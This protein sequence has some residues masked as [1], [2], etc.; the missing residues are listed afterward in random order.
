MIE[1]S[2]AT[3]DQSSA[4]APLNLA[5][6]MRELRARQGLKQS[7]IARRMG[8]DP[9]IPSLWEQGKRPVPASR[10]PALAAALGVDPRELLQGIPAPDDSAGPSDRSARPPTTEYPFDR[11]AIRE[12]VRLAPATPYLTLVATRTDSPK[13]TPTTEPRRAEW[14]HTSRPR[15]AG[16]VPDGWEPG[17]R[18]Q[19]VSPSLPDGLWLDPV[20]L[21]QASAR[22]LLRQR[23]CVPDQVVIEGQDVAGIVMAERL[24]RHCAQEP[25]FSTARIPLL[26]A[27][28]RAV[29][30]SD[31]G[32]LETDELI[33][34][35]DQHGSMMPITPALLRR[36]GGA[37]RPYPLRWVERE[38]FGA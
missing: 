10:V 22:S 20:R 23:L 36:V 33:A 24:H 6:R 15:M 16:F 32:G 5:P 34:A 11:F 13:A 21:E 26:E 12:P 7:E 37:A 29:L 3:A 8:L 30:R 35:L 38:L 27:M 14:A 31:R 9:S 2:S 1:N 25:G 18:I 19:D 17:D 28:F 4:G